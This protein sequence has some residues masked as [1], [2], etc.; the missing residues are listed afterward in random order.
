MILKNYKVKDRLPEG[1]YSG[2]IQSCTISSCERYV[3]FKI[4]VDND[5]TILNIN[6]P[7]SSKEYCNFADFF[8]DENGEYDTDDFIGIEIDFTL[9][10]RTIG[11]T[12]Y[13]KFKNLQPRNVVECE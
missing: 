9:V 8:T 5:N 10:D 6:I 7:I 12:V 11:D 2:V 1:E 13:S 3:W 4:D